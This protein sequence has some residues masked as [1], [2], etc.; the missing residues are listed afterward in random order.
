M[1]GFIII[2]I[3]ENY[4]DQETMRDLTRI[5][6]N[7]KG[8]NLLYISRKSMALNSNVITDVNCTHVF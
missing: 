5:K 6:T 2:I 7:H 4:K 1:F 3:L 8:S